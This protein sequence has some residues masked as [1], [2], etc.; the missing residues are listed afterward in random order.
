[1]RELTI[2]ECQFA[3]GGG[4]GEAGNGNSCPVLQGCGKKRSFLGWWKYPRRLTNE[5]TRHSHVGT[6]RVD[7]HRCIGRRSAAGVSNIASL[8]NDRFHRLHS[9][10][11]PCENVPFFFGKLP[12]NNFRVEGPDVVSAVVPDLTGD[13]RKEV[14]EI[15]LIVNGVQVPGKPFEV[16]PSTGII[17]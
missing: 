15:W 17:R 6:L 16:R 11:K 14:A 3:V 7:D 12:V 13:G 4:F 2:D 8:R 5:Q 10:K 1:M 9:R